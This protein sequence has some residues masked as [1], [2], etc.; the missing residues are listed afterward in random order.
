MEEVK[1]NDELDTYNKV[2]VVK[3]I[4]PNDKEKVIKITTS[5]N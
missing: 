1:I 4:D 5:I 3:V 2:Q